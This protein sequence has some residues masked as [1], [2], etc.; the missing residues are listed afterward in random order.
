[1]QQ[2]PGRRTQFELVAITIGQVWHEDLPDTRGHQATHRVRPAVPPVEIADRADALC[3]GRPDGEVH[4][5]RAVD[6]HAMGPEPFPHAVVGPLGKEVEIEIAQHLRE[7]VGIDH[8]ARDGVFAHAEP[9]HERVRGA[10]ERNRGLKEAFGTATL[11]AVDAIR[12]DQLH[13]TGRRRLHRPDHQGRT[14]IHG[15]AMTAEHGEWIVAPAGRDR[16]EHV[17]CG[18]ALTVTHGL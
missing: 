12:R 4:A 15:H 9:V 13:T 8:I 16:V 14:A 5:G 6:R 18:R 2:L 10:I 7:P 3:I 17:V 1:M 11:H